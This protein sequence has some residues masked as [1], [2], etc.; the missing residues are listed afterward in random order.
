MLAQ[1]SF[2]ATRGGREEQVGKPTLLVHILAQSQAV[3]YND[4]SATYS[5]IHRN[6]QRIGYCCPTSISSLSHESFRQCEKGEACSS[7]Y[8]HPVAKSERYIAVILTL[9]IFASAI[10]RT[11]RLSGFPWLPTLHGAL[12]FARG[13]APAKPIL[14]IAFARTVCPS[15]SRIPKRVG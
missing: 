12:W 6:S 15:Q 9:H 13:S 14:W 4:E 3:L 7:Q 2:T 11:Q 1:L 5:R 8:Q 10:T